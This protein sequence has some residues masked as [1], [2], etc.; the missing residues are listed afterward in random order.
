MDDIWNK[1]VNE[2]PFTAP[3]LKVLESRKIATCGELFANFAA[4]IMAASGIVAGAELFVRTE[5]GVKL[6]QGTPDEPKVGTTMIEG[7]QRRAATNVQRKVNEQVRQ[8]GATHPGF[9]ELKPLMSA[10]PEAGMPHLSSVERPNQITAPMLEAIYRAA[11]ALM[12][13][14]IA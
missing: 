9:N 5:K 11:K 14:R 6:R 2:L 10:M 12:D 1:P 8:F 7:M 4:H 3:M 13:R